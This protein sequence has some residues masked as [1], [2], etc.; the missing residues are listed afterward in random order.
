MTRP[1]GFTIIRN[2][3]VFAPDE[4]GKRDVLIAGGRV[5][6]IA[7]RLELP[8]GFKKTVV[9]ATDCSVAPGF[10][11]LHVHLVG[12]GGE[13]GP[14][15]RVTEIGLSTLIRA[16]I[17][18]VVGV[19]GTDSITRSL[20]GLL[21]KV[22]AL[23]ASG[24]GAYMYT[25]AYRFPSPTIT[26]SVARDI[27][28]VDE[29]VG[30]K[31]AISDH[32]SSQLTIDDLKRLAS[33]ARTGGMIG[34]KPGTVHV[35]V[36]TGKRGISPLFE[37]VEES[38]IPIAQFLPT[39]IARSPELLSQGARFVKQG[40]HIDVTTASKAEKT[41]AVIRALKESG[42]DLSGITLSSD[43][44]GSIPRFN[45]DGQLADMATGEVATLANTVRALVR[46]NTLSLADALTLITRNSADRLGVSDRKGSIREG[47]D[48]DIVVLDKSLNVRQVFAG[49]LL[50]L[51][52]GEPVVKG[53]FE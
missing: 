46:T 52:E 32:R 19:L 49:G 53:A 16:G 13:A 42:I 51:D 41:T 47:M 34:G 4:L 14:V 33:E 1:V 24:L 15:S 39:H 6:Q 8:K 35:H 22:K 28:L 43:G 11:D 40:G 9:D 26:G 25:G 48:A 30:V 37:V 5:A 27:A 18:T 38:E 7:E 12:G 17:T 36:G 20:E 23:R 2:G 44:N 45:G 29:I 21:A 31:I 50:L 10:I 3:N